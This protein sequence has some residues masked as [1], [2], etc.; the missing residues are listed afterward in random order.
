[1]FL[2]SLRV[3]ACWVKMASMKVLIGVRSGRALDRRG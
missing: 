1:M 2:R 3:V